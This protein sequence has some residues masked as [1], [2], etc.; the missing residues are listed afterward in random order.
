ME[1]EI[2]KGWKQYPK[3]TVE[4]WDEFISWEKRK[5]GEGKF[6][7]NILKKYNVNKVLDIACGT[8]YDSIRLIKEGFIVKS[9]DGSQ[10]MIKK[11]LQNADKEGVKLDI[12]YCD[13]R[14]LINKFNEKFD[15]IICLGNSFTHLFLEKDRIAVLNQIYYLL[16]HGGILIID[17]RNYDYILSKGYKSKHKYV[18]C[19]ETI[20]VDLIK[21]ENSLVRFKY[22][23]KDN[24][25]FTLDL[26][27]I[28]VKEMKNLL[29]K[30]GFSNIKTYG[31]FKEKF[32]INNTDFIQ[33]ISIK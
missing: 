17:Q 12:Y 3:K 8:G 2:S 15:A 1:N 32:D 9:C 7:I 14:S 18:Y 23:K 5:S 4:L 6:F 13:W 28:K 21:K 16:N 31:D 10:E 11:A 27:P 30:V 24:G 20:D 26:Y 29:E 19:G 22:T 25:S 33:H